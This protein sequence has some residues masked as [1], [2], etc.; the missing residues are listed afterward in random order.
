MP[1]YLAAVSI[2]VRQ[3]H[4]AANT[5]T[6]AAV[7]SEAPPKAAR[8]GD[9]GTS[10]CPRATVRS[11]SGPLWPPGDP[12]LG[13]AG[14]RRAVLHAGQRVLGQPDR[15]AIRAGLNRRYGRL[16]PPQPDRVGPQDAGLPALAQRRPGARGRGYGR[17]RPGPQRH[18]AER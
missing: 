4:K 11:L 9:V 12:P 10:G 18:V 6:C 13:A 14:E 2:E 15:G 17:G 16:G 3:A 7:G 5:M 8:G 1:P